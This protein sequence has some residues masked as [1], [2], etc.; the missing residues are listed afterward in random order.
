[1]SVDHH[2]NII[3]IEGV[4]FSYGQRSVLEHISFNVH[5][6]DYLGLVGPNGAG[7]TTLLKIMLGLLRPNS[8]QVRLF[9]QNITNF[10]EHSKISYVPQQTE[11]F[12]MNFPATVYEIVAMGRYSHL[13]L[14]KRLNDQ[15]KRIVQTSL[16]KVNLWGQ[17]QALIGELSGGQ[18]QRAFIARALATEPKIIFL[19]EAGRGLDHKT[20]TDFYDILRSLNRDQGITL[21]LVSHDI[22]RI[23]QEAMHIACLNKT[24]VCHDSPLD[25][26]R[27]SESI[28]I[29]GETA[30][31]LEHHHHH[32]HSSDSSVKH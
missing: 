27:H 2:K 24:L 16:E 9:G 14:G 11:R 13:G 25:F 21:V 12:D 31:V 15:D 19:D 20:E 5:Q 3:E 17:R 22:S 18:K 10:Q 29:F 8:G 26:L 23:S 30:R 32:N 7:K 1:M 6:G 4:S 28:K